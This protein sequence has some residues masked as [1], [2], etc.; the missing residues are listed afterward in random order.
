MR[1]R[2]EPGIARGKICAPA[3]KSMAHRMLIAAAMAEGVSTVR[4]VSD[5]DD[6]AATVDCLRAM[7]VKFDIS[8][9]TYRVFGIDFNKA[10][11]CGNLFCRE[12]G[13][14]LRFIIPAA[15]LS[16]ERVSFFGAEGLMRRP[17]T[18]F[19]ELYHERGFEFD[20]KDGII[21]VKGSLPVGDH[22]VPGN[23]SS[24]FI[25]G[26]IF[27]LGAKSG[28]SRIIITTPIESR[29]YIE[30]TML[31]VKEF[32]VNVFFESESTIKIEGRGGYSPADVTVE[33]DYSGAAFPDS[34]NLFGGEVE[35]SGLRDDS[36]QGD[37]IYKEYFRALDAKYVTLDIE[38]CPDLGPILFAIAAAKHGGRFTGTRRL[39]IKESDRAA[40]M[41]QELSKLGAEV[42][43]EE[44]SVTVRGGS[45]HAPKTRIFAHADHRIVMSVAVLLTLV[46]GVIEGAEA[47]KKSYPA[48]F[49]DLHA[50]GI[51]AIIEDE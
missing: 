26:L 48:F 20:T 45:L 4:G 12:S 43:I 21:S 51:G 38:N 19:E 15:T 25:S 44:N 28:D 46:G 7:G 47:V 39:K 17:M 3:S 35:I 1:V 16:G 34:L 24:Q 5:C 31:A 30:L 9:D 11:P 33:G 50:L 14:T 40:A 18:V 10:I 29:S 42:L 36:A 13:S 27:A 32:G 49:E 2:I 37:R 23:I 22:S 8:G 6:V 41:A